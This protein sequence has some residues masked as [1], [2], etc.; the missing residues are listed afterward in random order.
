MST[1]P[2]AIA[3]RASNRVG[4]S[5]GRPAGTARRVNWGNLP[6]SL[7]LHESCMMRQTKISGATDQTFIYGILRSTFLA[8]C[9]HEATPIHKARSYRYR[10]GTDGARSRVRQPKGNRSSTVHNPTAGCNG[11][12]FR[13]RLDPRKHGGSRGWRRKDVAER[14]VSSGQ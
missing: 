5:S 9:Y 3:Y 12:S 7:Q 2:P 10:C 4:F 6:A 13:C 11:S 8:P 1:P 14:R